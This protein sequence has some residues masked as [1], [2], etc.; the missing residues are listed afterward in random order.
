[1]MDSCVGG[2]CGCKQLLTLLG[3]MSRLSSGLEHGGRQMLG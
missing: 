3:G 1:M 2:S